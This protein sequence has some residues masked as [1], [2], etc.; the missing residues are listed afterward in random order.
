LERSR[1]VV[2]HDPGVEA[3]ENDVGS[4]RLFDEPQDGRIVDQ[5]EEDR[6][7]DEDTLH[8]AGVRLLVGVLRAGV[9]V[10]PCEDC[11]QIR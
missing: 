5:L 4:E 9:A 10:G 3:A 7:V 8:V 2:Q 6:I 1:Y 11:R